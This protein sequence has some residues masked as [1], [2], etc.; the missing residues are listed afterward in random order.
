MIYEQNDGCKKPQDFNIWLSVQ[1]HVTP[2]VQMNSQYL[3]CDNENK[4][5]NIYHDWHK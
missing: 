2:T 5:T 3:D 1:L 4:G